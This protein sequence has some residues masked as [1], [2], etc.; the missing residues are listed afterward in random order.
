[1]PDST[2]DKHS[3]VVGDARATLTATVKQAYEEQNKSIREIAEDTGRSYGAVHRMLKES[4]VTIR[5]RGGQLGRTRKSM[6]TTEAPTTAE[7]G[8]GDL[9]GK[10]N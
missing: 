9:R 1:M 4:G 7:Q 3:R 6:T 2:I 8:D 5:G 10:I